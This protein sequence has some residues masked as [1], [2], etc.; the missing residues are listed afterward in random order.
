MIVIVD[1]YD[2]FTYNLVHSI[3][4]LEPARE[5]RVVRNDQVTVPEIIEWK[6]SHVVISPGPCTPDEA[7]ISIECVRQLAGHVPLLGVCLGHQA[8]GAALGARII[9][10]PRPMHGKT[11]QI[12][13]TGAGLF[14]GLPSPITA[15]RYH[16]L[17]IDPAFC[18]DDITV[19]AWSNGT[20]DERQIM[21]I[22]HSRWPLFGVQF[23]PESFLTPRGDDLLR[24]FLDVQ[25]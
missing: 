23:H 25:A 10:A 20:P 14:E 18:H 17:V 2:S 1:N 15:T 16:S 9:R 3:G 11:D 24:A 7:G 22:Q 12:H 6:P 21:A 8:I 4:R 5:V 13:H 19:V